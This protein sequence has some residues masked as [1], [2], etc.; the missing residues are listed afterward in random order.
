MF[1]LQP[2]SGGGCVCVL[3]L[4]RYNK[5]T[6]TE[7]KE[8]NDKG[9]WVTVGLF[10]LVEG[11]IFCLRVRVDKW[12]EEHL[13][14]GDSHSDTSQEEWI[15]HIRKYARENKLTKG[16]GGLMKCRECRKEKMTGLR[17]IQKSMIVNGWVKEMMRGWRIKQ[18]CLLCVCTCRFPFPIS[19]FLPTSSPSSLSF[20]VQFFCMLW[21]SDAQ[22]IH[23]TCL[24]VS[25]WICWIWKAIQVEGQIVHKCKEEKKAVYTWIGKWSNHVFFFR[26]SVTN[27]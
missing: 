9:K 20:Q 25:S 26:G 22:G 10:F 5:N 13:D 24:D 27:E 16:K 6:N 11:F 2:L 3:D 7:E 18:E 19:S 8:E 15:N 4:N 12:A 21:P 17:T 14:C 1:R 23:F